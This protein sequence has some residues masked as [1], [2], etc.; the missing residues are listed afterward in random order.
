MCYFSDMKGFIINRSGEELLRVS[1]E[2]LNVFDISIY[3]S[4]K[5]EAFAQMNIHGITGIGDPS[6]NGR[7]WEEQ[8]LATNDSIEILF[9]D[10]V[11]NPVPGKTISELD[12]EGSKADYKAPTQE[13]ADNHLD[14]L[15][16]KPDLRDGYTLQLT[17]DSD[18]CEDLQLHCSDHC[19]SF[20]VIYSAMPDARVGAFLTSTPLELLYSK[21]GGTWHRRFELGMKK[22][23]SLSIR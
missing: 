14:E 23:V 22:S 16:Q 12:P 15:C 7:F 2:E 1:V 17:S 8:A 5:S 21:E 20:H 19:F 18:E 9:T 3:G 13:D 6:E 4:L 11:S 10:S